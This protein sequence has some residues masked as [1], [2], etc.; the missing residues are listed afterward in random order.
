M[1]TVTLLGLTILGTDTEVGKTYVA[2]RILESLV[3]DG[4]AAGAY[5]PVASGA[6]TIE[7][8]DG[9]QLWQASGKR[10]SLL[11]VCPQTFL[12]PLAP[13]IAAELEGKQVSDQLILDG[14]KAWSENCELLILEGAGGLMSPISWIMTNSDLA[15][16]MQFPVVLVSQN[17]LGVV[18]QVLTTLTAARSVGLTVACVVLNSPECIARGL[19]ETNERLLSRFV[20]RSPNSPRLVHLGE[21]TLEFQPKV[22]WRE[23][24]MCENS[25]SV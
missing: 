17:R 12:A 23:L 13:P 16:K 21:N 11:D 20:S 3:K 19:A 22:D 5:K 10:G 15:M 9:Y 2:C 1:G 18:N 4:V 14:A 24:A 6:S 8:S 7:Q 25:P